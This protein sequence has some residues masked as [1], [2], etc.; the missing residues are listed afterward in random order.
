[1]TKGESIGRVVKWKMDVL[2]GVGW[3]WKID[4]GRWREREEEEVEEEEEEER[5]WI[6]VGQWWCTVRKGVRG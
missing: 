2:V 6:E 4:G 3:W 5:M 1:M